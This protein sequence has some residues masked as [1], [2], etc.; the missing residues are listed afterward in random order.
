ML[1]LAA[2]LRRPLRRLLQQRWRRGAPWA[3]PQ[4][5]VQTKC[6]ELSQVLS[7]RLAP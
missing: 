5:Q 7:K 6:F 1:G 3:P 2:V 4:G